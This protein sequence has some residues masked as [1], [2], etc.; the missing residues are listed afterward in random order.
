MANESLPP[1][2]RIAQVT[3]SLVRGV[4]TVAGILSILT[5]GLGLPTFAVGF[6]LLDDYQTEDAG[7]VVLIVGSALL[8]AGLFFLPLGVA[9]AASRRRLAKLAMAWAPRLTLLDTLLHAGTVASKPGLRLRATIRGIIEEGGVG[10]L[11]VLA[12]QATLGFA[13]LLLVLGGVGLFLGGLGSCDDDA[14][15]ERVSATVSAVGAGL[16]VAG[17]TGIVIG[18]VGAVAG[19]R[20]FREQSRLVE[21]DWEH[22]VPRRG[23]TDG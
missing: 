19:K 22:L 13:L 1:L 7:F 15:C 18:L 20:A 14:D 2:G 17:C 11:R 9:R 23:Q 8:V 10:E 6:L 16:L 21:D 3:L 12:G 4:G 5:L